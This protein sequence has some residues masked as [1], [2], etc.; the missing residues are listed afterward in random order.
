MLARLVVLLAVLVACEGRVEEQKGRGLR[1]TAE[2]DSAVLRIEVVKG[3]I[4][5]RNYT[6]GNRRFASIPLSNSP[7]EPTVLSFGVEN[8]DGVYV[9][10]P[11]FPVIVISRYKGDLSISGYEGWWYAV[12]PDRK[13]ELVGSNYRVKFVQ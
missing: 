2:R 5:N 7:S 4:L 13:K 8:D 6:E 10:Q 3:T 1:G 11:D 9:M 12:V